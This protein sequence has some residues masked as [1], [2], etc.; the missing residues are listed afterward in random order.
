[1]YAR[2]SDYLGTTNSV[3]AVMEGSEPTVAIA[4]RAEVTFAVGFP[5]RARRWGSWPCQGVLNPENTVFRSRGSWAAGTMKLSLRGTD[6]TR[7]AGQAR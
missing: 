4:R 7:S 1:M 6:P 2:L 5:K 3:I